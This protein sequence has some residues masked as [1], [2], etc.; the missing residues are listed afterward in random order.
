MHCSDTETEP[1]VS[2]MQAISLFMCA[3]ILTVLLHRKLQPQHPITEHITQPY[4][5]TAHQH[6]RVNVVRSYIFYSEMHDY[7][8]P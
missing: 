2:C 1:F 4:Q 8:V 5:R 6:Q 7:I 3:E